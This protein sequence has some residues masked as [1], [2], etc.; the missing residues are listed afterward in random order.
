MRFLESIKS[1]ISSLLANRGRLILGI[2]SISI[3]VATLMSAM[4]LSESCKAFLRKEIEKIGV[5]LIRIAPKPSPNFFTDRDVEMIKR[6][7]GVLK[8]ATWSGANFGFQVQYFNKTLKGILIIDWMPQIKEM[9]N[10][11]LKYGRFFTQQEVES[12]CNV[13]VIGKDLAYNLFGETNPVGEN[14][15]M[16]DNNGHR[17]SVRVVGVLD[18]VGILQSNMA[19]VSNEGII[20]PF[21]YIREKIRAGTLPRKFHDRVGTIMVQTKNGVE[22]KEVMR[23][24][25]REF[26]LHRNYSCRFF[27]PEDLITYEYK[28]LRRTTLIGICI[29]IIFLIVGGIGIMN[30]MLKSV[31]ERTREI[32]IRKAVGAKNRDILTQFLAEA[33]IIGILGCLV[34][35]L[36]GIGV[37][38]ITSGWLI[39][40]NV[41]I[42]SLQTIFISCGAALILSL[43]FG[44]YPAY[45]ASSLTPID[46]LRYE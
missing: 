31:I 27:T 23:Q 6:C 41:V 29:A 26:A 46:A 18:E 8:V 19:M 33:F 37:A 28:L 15:F 21:L 38:Y 39:K 36:I 25:E 7:S 9:A 11:S 45:R 2:V 20:L 40:T 17:F 10:L 42:I 22:A 24:I 3:G 14:I 12:R 1:S 30:I 34:G 13:G 16:I 43:L 4:V 5:K 32:G 44:L 35:I